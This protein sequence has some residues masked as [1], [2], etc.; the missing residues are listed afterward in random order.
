MYIFTESGFRVSIR[1]SGIRG[2]GFGEGL[3]PKSVLGS[4][5]SLGAHRL[6]PIRTRPVAILSQPFNNV[7]LSQQI[8][9]ISQA[10]YKQFQTY[11]YMCLLDPPAFGA[12]GM[13]LS[14][15]GCVMSTACRK[16]HL[17][18]INWVLKITI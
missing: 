5:S 1:V 13:K 3:S 8:K 11:F 6:H 4:V 7:F 16:A 9:L 15:S 10:L 17:E 14:T 2:F 18:N 12:S